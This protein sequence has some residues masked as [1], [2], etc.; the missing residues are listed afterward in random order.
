MRSESGS[1]TAR[2]RPPEGS[3]GNVCLQTFNPGHRCSHELEPSA[4]EVTSSIDF[5]FP[6]DR[7]PA[8]S[9]PPTLPRYRELQDCEIS[10]RFVCIFIDISHVTVTSP[11][12]HWFFFGICSICFSLRPSPAVVL[13]AFTSLVFS[14][15]PSARP[16]LFKK[17]K[18]E[19]KRKGKTRH[20]LL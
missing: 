19:K 17:K 13:G 1:D 5:L 12:F 6:E 15:A 8:P 11:P 16:A 18:N 14:F 9:D 20:V 10:K 3:G 2:R 4:A 7:S